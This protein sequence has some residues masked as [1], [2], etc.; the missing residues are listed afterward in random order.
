MNVRKR[1][2]ILL[3]LT[4]AGTAVCQSPIERVQS[5]TG[6][7]YRVNEPFDMVIVLASWRNLTT[8]VCGQLLLA[9]GT[10]VSCAMALAAGC[11]IDLDLPAPVARLLD[12]SNLYVQAI[13]M[14]ARPVL[15]LDAAPVEKLTVVGDLD[16]GTADKHDG[17]TWS[18]DETEALFAS[19]L[20]WLHVS[21]L[22][23]DPKISTFG[24]YAEFI[25]RNDGY[26]LKSCGHKVI[27]GRAQV[28]LELKVPGPGQGNRDVVQ[29]HQLLVD[30]GRDGRSMDVHVA[31]TD[32][33][34]RTA[35]RPFGSYGLE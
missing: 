30:L 32:G 25:G 4:L 9:D 28:W 16:A 11:Q 7:T 26:G 19:N 2:A 20:E 3:T 17:T 23:M 22:V 6:L 35:F 13:G 24:L 10:M 21:H 29:T 14:K 31:I 15:S 27:D 18:K 8:G 34:R 33:Q 5:K 1:V 12:D